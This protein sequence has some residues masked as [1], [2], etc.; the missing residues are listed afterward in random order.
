MM[1]KEAKLVIERVDFVA[2]AEAVHRKAEEALQKFRE[3]PVD[4]DR[5][6]MTLYHESILVERVLKAKHRAEDVR[7]AV[8]TLRTEFDPTIHKKTSFVESQRRAVKIL[9]V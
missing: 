4:M 8:E 3:Q 6:L 5:P 1:V 9:G 7:N 2:S